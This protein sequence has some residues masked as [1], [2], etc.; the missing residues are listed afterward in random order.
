MSNEVRIRK[1]FHSSKKFIV[2][3]K[4]TYVQCGDM[5]EL[6]GGHKDKE[7]EFDL[8]FKKVNLKDYENRVK[9]IATRIKDSVDTQELVEQALFELPLESIDILEK[10]LN[11]PKVKIKPEKGCVILKVGNFPLMLRE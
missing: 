2:I 10:Q 4:D 5:D 6:K 8:I 7:G 11:K 1:A 9:D 3:G